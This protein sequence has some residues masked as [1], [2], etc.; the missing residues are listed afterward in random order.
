MSPVT[1]EMVDEYRAQEIQPIEIDGRK[2]KYNPS[3][4]AIDLDPYPPLPNKTYDGDEVEQL[5]LDV[6]K[7]ARDYDQVSK[8]IE[9]LDA[10]AEQLRKTYDELKPQY[11]RREAK[12][13]F[14]F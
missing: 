9:A 5:Q 14:D 1:Q 2:F 12:L 3:S 7:K 10:E 8:R 13:T 6:K 4:L 11:D